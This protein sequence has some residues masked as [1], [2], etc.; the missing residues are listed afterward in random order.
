VRAAAFRLPQPDAGRVA[1][2]STTLAN[3]DQVVLEVAR[4]VPGPKDALTDDERNNLGRQLAIQTGSGQFDK[5]LDSLRTKTKIVT[6]S[7]RL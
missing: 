7:D 5:L 1:L 3:G 4:V 2:G 6:Y